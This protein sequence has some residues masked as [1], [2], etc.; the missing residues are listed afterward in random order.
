[1]NE[2]I[3]KLI[4]V[5]LLGIVLTYPVNAVCVSCGASS[6]PSGVD[7]T[8]NT[9]TLIVSD[10]YDPTANAIP[11]LLGA[12]ISTGTAPA[13]AT[14]NMHPG[15]IAMR[16]YTTAAAGYR[17][18]CAGTQLIGGGETFEAIFQPVGVRVGQTAK[19]GW[20]DSAVAAT[21]PVDGIFFNISANGAA[22]TLRGNTSANSVRSGTAT[23]FTPTTATWYRG[24]IIV[25]PAAT[26]ITYTIYN[27]AG[28][29]EWT[30]T[31]A[32]NIPTAAGRDTSPCL[33]VSESSTDGAADILRMDYVR[34]GT[35]RILIR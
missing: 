13:V 20:S 29:Q 4:I 25:N 21:L 33:I 11:G 14:T 19:M 31:V 3:K 18:G 26:L 17:F 1:M 10:F 16:D 2:H 15:V 34:W 30:D 6:S 24:T 32:T 12:A 9:T 7:Y 27:D 35:T 22:I 5:I 28:V 8:A 23:T